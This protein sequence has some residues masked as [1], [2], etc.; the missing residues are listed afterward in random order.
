MAIVVGNILS[1]IALMFFFRPNAMLSGGV[2]G[3]SL[4]FG[5]LTHLPVSL[6]VVGINIPLVFLAIRYLNPTFAFFSTLSTFIFSGYL[7]LIELFLPPIAVTKDPLLAAI[8]GGVCNGVGMGIMFR[9]GT[10]QGGMDI[11]GALFRK[12]RGINVGKVLMSVNLIVIGIGA[13]VYGVDRGLYTLLGL[14]VAYNLLDRIQTGVGRMKQVFIISS[15]YKAITQYIHEDIHRG[16]TFFEG[17]GSYSHS[18][19]H[20]LYCI[21]TTRQLVR[22]RSKVFSI[23][24]SAFMAVSETVEVDGR[25]FQGIDM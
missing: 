20:V 14:F 24:P 25:G 12:Y 1:A 22:L 11:V 21:V 7:Y 19:R 18:P 16:V 8:F 15:K 5:A 13:L 6:F 17:M 4:L 23:D 9:Y 3:M 10:C 2:G